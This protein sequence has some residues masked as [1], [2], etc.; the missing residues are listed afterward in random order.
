MLQPS[1]SPYPSQVLL[2]LSA[3]PTNAWTASLLTEAISS[4][5][6]L[7]LS[8]AGWV[9]KT[10][11]SAHRAG[12]ETGKCETKSPV[13]VLPLHT[14]WILVK[15][16]LYSSKWNIVINSEGEWH[17]LAVIPVELAEPVWRSELPWLLGLRAMSG[18][19]SVPLIPRLGCSL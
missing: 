6:Q 17:R 9:T 14:S 2:L 15:S 19:L 11:C 10:G 13:P 12:L 1:S 5:A 16:F 4:S 3:R 8:S 7:Q 18:H